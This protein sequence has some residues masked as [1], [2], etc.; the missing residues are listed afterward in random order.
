MANRP[1]RIQLEV[2]K[3]NWCSRKINLCKNAINLCQNSN[4]QNKVTISN[5]CHVSLCQIACCCWWW[6]C[7]VLCVF[8][9]CCRFAGLF[10]LCGLMVSFTNSI[11][12]LIFG[13]ILVLFHFISV[14]GNCLALCYAKIICRAA[15]AELQTDTTKTP[16][17]CFIYVYLSNVILMLISLHYIYGMKTANIMTEFVS[18]SYPCCSVRKIYRT[19]NVSL[20]RKVNTNSNVFGKKNATLHKEKWLKIPDPHR[21]TNPDWVTFN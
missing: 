1:I 17:F 12:C 4:N 20:I 21:V 19:S 3:N 11:I 10:R 5:N 18:L 6:V 13:L 9:A 16:T 7:R 15:Y 14:T 2:P 8:V